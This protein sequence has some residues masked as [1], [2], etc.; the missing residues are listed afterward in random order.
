MSVHY[1]KVS[2]TWIMDLFP[3]CSRNVAGLL[4]FS[5]GITW[6]DSALI[7]NEWQ[8]SLAQPIKPIDVN[9]PL[10][11]LLTSLACVLLKVFRTHW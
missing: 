4:S 2:W 9:T 11:L 6:L 3:A 8:L 1:S 10:L 7:D 5:C